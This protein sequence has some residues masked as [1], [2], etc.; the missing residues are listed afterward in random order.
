[1]TGFDILGIVLCVI[2]ACVIGYIIVT[3]GKPPRALRR[4]E[5]K[6]VRNG[7]GSRSRNKRIW[8]GKT[9]KPRPAPPGPNGHKR[10]SQ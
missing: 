1:M 5:R 9:R 8:R 7:K 2:A 6:A 4:A 3:T 10:G